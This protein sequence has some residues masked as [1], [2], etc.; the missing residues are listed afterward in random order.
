[1]PIHNVLIE[2]D[3]NLDLKDAVTGKK[4]PNTTFNTSFMSKVILPKD[5]REE[6]IYLGMPIKPRFA[7]KPLGRMLDL[8]FELDLPKGFDKHAVEDW[9]RG[10]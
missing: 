10:M 1:M 2:W 3:D 9:K 4:I 6:E 5:F 8:W 7:D